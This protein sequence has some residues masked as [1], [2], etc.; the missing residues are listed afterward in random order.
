MSDDEEK[1]NVAFEAI[2]DDAKKRGVINAD[3]GYRIKRRFRINSTV[4][5]VLIKIVKS[6]W[7]YATALIAAALAEI[8]DLINVV[9]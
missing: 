4:S 6:W 5:K 2:V 1:T 7:T 9:K 3:E 8:T